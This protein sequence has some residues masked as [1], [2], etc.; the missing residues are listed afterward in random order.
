VPG[1]RILFMSEV[2]LNRIFPS[3]ANGFP[4]EWIE[5]LKRAEQMDAEVFVPAHG[6][7]DSPAV[8]KEEMHNYRLAIE[9]VVSEGRRL[10]DARVPVDAA[11]DRADFGPYTGWT[12]RS[13][14]AAGALKRVYMQLD[15]Q[16]R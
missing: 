12:R 9:R 13:D 6:F 11:S 5:T 14:N 16:L 4:S 2:F 8:L 3:M 1:D 15:G 7:V 10:H